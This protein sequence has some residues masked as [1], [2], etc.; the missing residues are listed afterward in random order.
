MYRRCQSK[1]EFL[2]CK[3]EIQK[4]LNDGFSIIAIYNRLKEKKSIN[5]TYKVLC[6]FIKKY[7]INV[8]VRPSAPL[9]SV[10]SRVYGERKQDLSTPGTPFVHNPHLD[11]SMFRKAKE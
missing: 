10:H 3:T 2:S 7:G 11:P 8:T 1:V 9:S 6:Y 4:L 5:L